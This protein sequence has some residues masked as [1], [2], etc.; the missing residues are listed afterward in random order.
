MKA[1]IILAQNL[2]CQEVGDIP[3]GKKLVFKDKNRKNVCLENLELVDSKQYLEDFLRERE[4][5]KNT[6]SIRTCYFCKKEYATSYY[7]YSKYC[8]K[9]CKHKDRL[10]SMKKKKTLKNLPNSLD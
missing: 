7:D 5:R 2:W 10:L 4:I 8:S 6:C 3:P 1:H 9:E